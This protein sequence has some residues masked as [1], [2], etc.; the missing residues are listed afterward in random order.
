[1]TLRSLEFIWRDFLLCLLLRITVIYKP[2]SSCHLK[3]GGPIGWDTS[4]WFPL[5]TQFPLMS[6]C[7]SSFLLC[8]C[9]LYPPLVK[10]YSPCC[11]AKSILPRKPQWHHEWMWSLD[12]KIYWIRQKAS[13]PFRVRVHSVSPAWTFDLWTLNQRLTSHQLLLTTPVL[14]HSYGI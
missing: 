12:A 4:K 3:I 6:Q 1:M 5:R 13:P 14:D 11:P 8:C 7:S 9:D 10:V 2:S